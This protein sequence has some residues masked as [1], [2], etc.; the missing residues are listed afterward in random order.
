MAR[1]MADHPESEPFRFAE[2]ASHLLHR[3]E[4]LASDRFAQ[5]AGNA[6]TLRQFAVL[7]A[8]SETPGLSQSD[9]VTA[10]SIDRSTLAD[11]VARLVKREFV[12]RPPSPTDARA[13]SVRL[14]QAGDAALAASINHARAAD[15]AILDLLPRTKRRTFLSTLTKLAKLADKARERAERDAR[16][17]AK[18]DSK[19]RDA[20]NKREKGLGK[21][22]KSKSRK[23]GRR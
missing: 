22:D 2:S 10:T 20:K 16:R 21:A 4:Q 1:S 23:P 19:K 14:T 17:Q 8:V 12:I 3:A 11:I 9:L 13:Y 15:A 18:R 5:L 7:A 6:L